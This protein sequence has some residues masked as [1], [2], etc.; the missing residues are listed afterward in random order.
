MAKHDK[1][2]E[3]RRMRLDAHWFLLKVY[4]ASS[5]VAHKHLFHFE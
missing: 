1:D 2:K 5:K 3:N 4:S